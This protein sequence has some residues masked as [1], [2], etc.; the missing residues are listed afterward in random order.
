MGI[1][2]ALILC[3]GFGVRLNPLTLK[4]PK[5]LLEL[6]NVTMLENCINMLIQLG[7]KKIIL[8]TFHLSHQIIEFI[9]KKKLFNRNSSYKWWE[10]NL[11]Y[12]G[13]NFKYD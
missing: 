11:R 1:N 4:T 5:P 12:W 3:A 2:T 10:N 13:R 8:N 9:K 6:N 7:I